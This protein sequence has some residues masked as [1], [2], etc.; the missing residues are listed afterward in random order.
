MVVLEKGADVGGVWSTEANDSSR[1]NTSE[2][3]YRLLDRDGAM[4]Q[5]H[6]PA[7][8]VMLD[9]AQIASTGLAHR[10][11]LHALVVSVKNAPAMN[12][13]GNPDRIHHLVE[14]EDLRADGEPVRKTIRANQ[15]VLCVNR[16]LGKMRQVS[17]KDENAFKG[18]I[19][20]GIGNQVRDLDFAGKRVLVVG[21]GAFANENART[22]IEKG[23]AGVVVLCRRRGT[24]MPYIM[25]YLSFVRPLN[26]EFANSV[27]GSA[28][29]QAAWLE[30]FNQCGVHPPECWQE[31]RVAPTGH[32][33][34]VSD[35]W[36][37]AHHYGLLT[38]RSY[39]L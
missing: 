21:G 20:Y 32:S 37:V 1:V 16:R 24:V 29:M 15:V 13:D 25:D 2:P 9:C 27:Y 3:A 38:T 19:C 10:I 5:F 17:F 8:Q 33:V 39:C 23:A 31:G 11:R 28:R 6:T 4:N 14:Y 30:A 7:S 36:M 22:A 35:M 34:S 12:S 26:E 18:V